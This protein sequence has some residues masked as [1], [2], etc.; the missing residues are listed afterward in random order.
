MAACFAHLKVVI[1]PSGTSALAAAMCGRIEIISGT[2]GVVLPGGN[3]A[4]TTL[5]SLL[6]R[7]ETAGGDSGVPGLHAWSRQQ[8]AGAA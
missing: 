6:G 8:P 7:A 4:W 5:R 3:T 2:I 1:E